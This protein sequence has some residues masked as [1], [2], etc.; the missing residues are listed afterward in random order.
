[1]WKSFNEIINSY[2]GI[3]FTIFFYLALFLLLIAN[4]CPLIM[5]HLSYYTIAYY[6]QLLRHKLIIESSQNEP[7]KGNKSVLLHLHEACKELNSIFSFPL[8]YI[9]TAKLVIVSTF[10]FLLI[11]GLVKPSVLVPTSLVL[12]LIAQIVSYLTHLLVIFHAADMPAYQ[13]YSL[14][15]H[16]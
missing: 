7:F 15:I 5:F 13:V 11:Y 6:I 3:I 10:S 1:M 16:D 2:F 14:I 9:I 8:L 4:D 12:F